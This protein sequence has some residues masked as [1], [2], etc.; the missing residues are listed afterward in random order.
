MR[1][2]AQISHYRIE[3]LLGSGGM[4]RVYRAVD[5]RLGRR[6][7]LKFLTGLPNEEE[8]Q[9]FINEARAVSSLDHPNICTI[10]EVDETAAGEIFIAMAYYE[11]ET[12]ERVIA[13]GPSRSGAGGVDRRSDGA[14]PGRRA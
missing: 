13:R 11:G 5:E 9:R 7:A 2:E 12:L 4:G 8:R 10:F 3:E 6:V 14:R 1:T